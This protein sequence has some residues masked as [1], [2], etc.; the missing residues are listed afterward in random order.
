[1]PVRRIAASLALASFAAYGQALL[2]DATIGKLVK[3]GIGEQTIVTMIDKQPGKYS[4][5]SGDLTALKNAG[6]SDRILAAMIEKNGSVAKPSAAPAQMAL[7][8]ATPIRL[9][10]G[11]ELNFTNVKP[12][13]R[14]I[15]GTRDIPS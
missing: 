8:D 15:E 13:E 5:T 2:D 3:A 6:A 12:G 9:R 10:L 4:L 1:M 7:H 14:Q 11:R